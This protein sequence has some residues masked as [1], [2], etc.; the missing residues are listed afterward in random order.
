M[1]KGKTKFAESIHTVYN[2]NTK[3]NDVNGL[4]PSPEQKFTNASVHFIRI[5]RPRL[6]FLFLELVHLVLRYLLREELYVS[7]IV[8]L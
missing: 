4:L 6:R 8:L 7:T 3:S 5:G 2:H 1:E